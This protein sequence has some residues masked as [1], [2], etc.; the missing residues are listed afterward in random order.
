MDSSPFILTARI[1]AEAFAWFERLR[2]QYFPAER[3]R[4]GAHLTLFHLLPPSAESEIR[5]AC[6]AE[7]AGSGLIAANAATLRFMGRGFAVRI[8]SWD[9]SMLRDRLADRFAL[10]LSAQDRA[11][12]QPHVTI[13]NKAEPKAAR[14]A[15]N[16]VAVTFRPFAFRLTGLSLWR[17]RGG[18]WE[19][20]ASYAFR[21]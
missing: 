16:A 12:F 19:A 21:A 1:D 8:E 2:T 15:M 7:A 18:P 6:A 14:A 20:A 9:L 3:R 17:Y 5:N 11:P 13:M 4:V 10:L